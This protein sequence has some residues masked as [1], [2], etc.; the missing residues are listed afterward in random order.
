MSGGTL[1]HCF[2]TPRLRAVVGLA[3]PISSILAPGSNFTTISPCTLWTCASLFHD[4][5]TCA[6]SRSRCSRPGR[7]QP[8][9]PSYNV[10]V[11]YL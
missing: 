11:I 8:K 7:G 2:E 9:N 5:R 3:G 4:R 1:L 6:G 10:D